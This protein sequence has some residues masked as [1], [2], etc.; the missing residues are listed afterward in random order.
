MQSRGGR[1]AALAEVGDA[2][3]A[4]E[5]GGGPD[6]ALAS[7]VASGRRHI[8]APALRRDGLGAHATLVAARPRACPCRQQPISMN[9]Y[10][11]D[12]ELLGEEQNRSDFESRK[13]EGSLT[14]AMCEGQRC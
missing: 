10:T 6:A 7:R 1:A 13:K 11:G 2:V 9:C 3:H 4:L 8:L 14:L 12:F 5:A